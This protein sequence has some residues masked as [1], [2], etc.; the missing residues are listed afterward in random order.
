MASV[1]KVIV[2]GNL[3]RDPEVR[4]SAEGNAMCN[5]SLATSY[6]WR[7][8]NT[9]ER[10]EQTEWHRVVMFGRLAEVAGEY[11][12]KGQSVYIEGRLQTRKW[13][14]NNGIERYTTEIVA[15]QMQMLGSRSD[16]AQTQQPQQQQ[17]MQQQQ[18]QQQQPQQQQ[19]QQQQMQQQPQQQMQQHQQ[20][21][22]QHAQNWQ[23]DDI[24][25]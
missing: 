8:R 23:D 19:P 2:L 3:G 14:D 4:Y 11:L 25:F 6:S 16:N 17:Q 1:N 7:D 21:P 12:N 5:L 13:T 9:G 15:E 22:Q 24:P 18:M 10:R 20:Q